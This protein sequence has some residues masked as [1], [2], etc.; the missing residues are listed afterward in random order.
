MS[1]HPLLLTEVSNTERTHETKEFVHMT[2]RLKEN[3]VLLKKLLQSLTD[4]YNAEAAAMEAFTS[5]VKCITAS[6]DSHPNLLPYDTGLRS[7]KIKL[8]KRINAI[9]V[10]IEETLNVDVSKA[11][12]LVDTVNNARLA[13]DAASDSYRE[14]F[15]KPTTPEKHKKKKEEMMTASKHYADSRC[16]SLFCRCCLFSCLK[17]FHCSRRILE[18]FGNLSS[19]VVCARPPASAVIPHAFVRFPPIVLSSSLHFCF[20]FASKA[21]A[22]RRV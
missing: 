22:D 13:F 17:S 11:E 18:A 6:P 14:C 12:D 16:V 15:D 7:A 9:I 4:H 5:L 10:K 19:P 21:T 8:L 2:E 3:R 20:A 1:H